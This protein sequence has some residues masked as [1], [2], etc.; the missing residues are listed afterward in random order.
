MHA[1]SDSCV[2]ASAFN[3]ADQIIWNLYGLVSWNENKTVGF[4]DK[5][6][7]LAEIIK[8]GEFRSLPKTGLT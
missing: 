6:F 5:S 4:Q 8:L 1:E 3:Q 7:S 2:G